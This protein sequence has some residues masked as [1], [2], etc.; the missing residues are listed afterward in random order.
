[1]DAGRIMADLVLIITRPSPQFFDDFMG[2]AACRH[3]CGPPAG[4]TAR[5][6]RESAWVSLKRLREIHGSLAEARRIAKIRALIGRV[7][8]TGRAS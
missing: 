1:M 3:D 5:R 6:Q 7:G 2:V 8:A 4:A